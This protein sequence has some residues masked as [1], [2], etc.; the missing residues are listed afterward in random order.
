MLDLRRGRVSNF[1]G[2]PAAGDQSG[3]PT[4]S[5]A[6]ECMRPLVSTFAAQRRA[7]NRRRPQ[8]LAGR[9][10]GAQQD[11]L[12]VDSFPRDVDVV[13]RP[14]CFRVLTGSEEPP[15]HETET[16]PVQPDRVVAQTI[17]A[18]CPRVTPLVRAQHDPLG[19]NSITAPETRRQRLRVNWPLV[20]PCP[21]PDSKQFPSPL[22]ASPARRHPRSR[23]GWARALG[24]L[25]LA[26]VLKVSSKSSA[27]SLGL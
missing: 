5:N 6:C 10:A 19:V 9:V 24:A 11:R 4:D 7:G 20:H 13:R 27:R 26:G 2:L 8:R 18:A 15:P 23:Q 12:A 1:G 21:R 16:S 17:C 14:P 3:F 25:R 22:A